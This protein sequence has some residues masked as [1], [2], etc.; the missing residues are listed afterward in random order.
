M[1]AIVL[2]LVRSTGRR[3]AGAEESEVQ[4]IA[5]SLVEL[6]TVKLDIAQQLLRTRRKVG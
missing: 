4:A 6:G 5:D 2:H 3:E 1:I